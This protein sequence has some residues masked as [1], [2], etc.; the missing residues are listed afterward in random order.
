MR[1]IQWAEDQLEGEVAATEPFRTKNGKIGWKVPEGK[2]TLRTAKTTMKGKIEQEWK[3]DFAIYC[4]MGKAP[5]TPATAYRID[6]GQ[7]ALHDRLNRS[8]SSLAIAIRTEKIGLRAFLTMRRVPG[9]TA[10]CE[11]GHTRQTAK[12]IIL[13]CERYEEERIALMEEL[14][15]TDYRLITHHPGKLRIVTKW[16]MGLGI[17]EQYAIAR[18]EPSS[19]KLWNNQ[20]DCGHLQGAPNL[21]EAAKDSMAHAWQLKSA[22]LIDYW[23]NNNPETVAERN[24]IRE[25]RRRG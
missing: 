11:C 1:K 18:I 13:F 17:L 8:E 7:I 12:H 22:E 24:R 10:E 15:S 25:T 19:E 4:T 6:E 9:F 5:N 23:H 20:R 2:Q 21:S 14:D 3:N 16:L